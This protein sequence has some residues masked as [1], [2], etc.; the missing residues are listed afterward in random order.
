MFEQNNLG[1]KLKKPKYLLLY[2]SQLVLF[3]SLNEWNN[4]PHLVAAN[5]PD[6]GDDYYSAES[7]ARRGIQ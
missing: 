7:F 2:F 3:A 1:H 4:F 6:Y 5:Q